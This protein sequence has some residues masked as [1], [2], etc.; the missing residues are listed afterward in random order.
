MT[1]AAAPKLDWRSRLVT[2]I[3]GIKPIAT[4]AKHQA[5]RMI[6]NRAA[7]IGESWS[8]CVARLQAVDWEPYWATVANPS[9]KYPEYY[10][11]PFHAYAQG[12]LSWD[13]AW[14]LEV[15]AQAV[16][17]GIWP[18][19]PHTQGDQKL[20]ACYHG[21]LRSAVAHLVSSTPA[22]APQ[23]MLDLGC[24]VGLSTFALQDEYPDAEI[25]GLDLSPYFLAVAQYNS[26]QQARSIQWIHSAAEQTPCPDA[27]FDLVSASLVFHELP[28]IAAQQILQEARRLLRPGGIFAL[29]D[30][31]PQSDVYQRMPSYVLTLLKSTEPYLDQY[32]TLDLDRAFSA[33]GF[34]PP[35][36]QPS[37]HRHRVVV[38][39]VPG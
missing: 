21:I 36:I 14:E 20:R 1:T 4:V 6:M 10:Q 38:A 35:M 23:R 17:A 12:N 8:D 9:L 28:A 39:T 22:T 2:I 26:E 5:R 18:G 3:L 11:Y 34:N 33:A 16:H 29:M 32:F 25:V 31:N 27:S 30:M 13:A 7:Q 19:P 37:T 15:A 24:G